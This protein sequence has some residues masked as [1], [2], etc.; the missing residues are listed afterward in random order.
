MDAPWALWI[1][2]VV[3]MIPLLDL[4]SISLRMFYLKTA[5]NQAV[6][7]AVRCQTFQSP[8]V[9]GSTTYPSAKTTATT[10]ATT[11]AN[12][13][14]GVHLGTVK[15][16]IIHTAIP[17]SGAGAAPAPTENPLPKANGTPDPTQFVVSLRVT[18]TGTVDPFISFNL[19]FLSN[20]PGLSGPMTF[21][22]SSEEKF[23]NLT[24]LLD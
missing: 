5:A 22:V 14:S 6:H 20:I 1:L 18:L 12:S 11:T 9:V 15:V 21:T 19:P 17:G 3:L 2:F 4:G 13:F 10:V 23:E 16:E 8:F 7:A 24:G